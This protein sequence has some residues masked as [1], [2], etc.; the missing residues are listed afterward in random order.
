MSKEFEERIESKG[1]EGQT[2]ANASDVGDKDPSDNLAGEHAGKTKE[3]ITDAEGKVVSERYVDVADGAK[4]KASGEEPDTDAE[5]EV[6]AAAEE[7]V[8][9]EDGDEDDE[10]TE[11]EDEA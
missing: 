8:E 4:G 3:T 1:L 7:G 11:P 2:S 6:E 5:L 9:V 10:E